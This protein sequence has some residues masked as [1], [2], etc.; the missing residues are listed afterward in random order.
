MLFYAS[1]ID[2]P[3]ITRLWLET[4]QLYTLQNLVGFSTDQ[5]LSAKQRYAC[6]SAAKA[7]TAL[8]PKAYR[9]M[10]NI[11]MH[12]K[13]RRRGPLFEENLPLYDHLSPVTQAIE[14]HN[15]TIPISTEQAWIVEALFPQN[16]DSAS[17]SSII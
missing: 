15:D 8:L 13:I 12:A 11:N 10:I 2:S 3:Q 14:Y 17:N 7:M 16:S 6:I 9:K 1:W 4:W 5:R